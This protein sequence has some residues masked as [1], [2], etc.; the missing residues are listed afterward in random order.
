LSLNPS[1]RTCLA[2]QFGRRLRP[3]RKASRLSARCD[4][5][6]PHSGGLVLCG[7]RRLVS[8]EESHQRCSV[9]SHRHA[10]YACY[11]AILYELETRGIS[12]PPGSDRTILDEL[13]FH[14]SR[15]TRCDASP[16]PT[17]TVDMD[18]DW[19]AGPELH[20]RFKLTAF[21]TQESQAR[22]HLGAVGSTDSDR[23]ACV[24]RLF[25]L[26]MNAR[27]LVTPH[28]SKDHQRVKIALTNCVIVTFIIR[29]AHNLAC[30]D[31]RWK[32]RLGFSKKRRGRRSAGGAFLAG[33]LCSRRAKA[34]FGAQGQPLIRSFGGSQARTLSMISR[35]R[36]AFEASTGSST[37]LRSW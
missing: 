5:H 20:V 14:N 30:V 35:T 3:V 24:T 31:D 28:F 29:L 27:H 9:P 13:G 8:L 6:Q 37:S 19:L 11:A 2:R 26:R 32:A 22:R 33:V 16:D 1:L 25:Q 23:C 36:A 4:C 7:S 15:A 10:T 18:A 34:R 17:H 21:V 12:V